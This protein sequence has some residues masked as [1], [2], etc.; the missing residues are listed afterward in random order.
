MWPSPCINIS[1]IFQ[2]VGIKLLGGSWETGKIAFT[3]PKLPSIKFSLY[4]SCRSH[5]LKQW[6]S[7]WDQEKIKLRL[8]PSIVPLSVNDELAFVAGISC[9]L[10]S[11][12][13]TPERMLQRRKLLSDAVR[14]RNGI[15]IKRYFMSDSEQ[16]KPGERATPPC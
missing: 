7:W 15:R 16:H 3:A 5:N 1:S 2:L 10:N 14:E 8:P 6:L 12:S 11:P 9:Y 4:F 13:F